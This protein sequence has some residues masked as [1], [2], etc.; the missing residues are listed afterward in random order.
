ML[1]PS[2]LRASAFTLKS[3]INQSI[4]LRKLIVKRHL[5]CNNNHRNP[6]QIEK[7]VR[8]VRGARLKASMTLC[9]A[10]FAFES[11]ED[12]FVTEEKKIDLME[13]LKK[14]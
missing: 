7:R 4:A 13:C 12:I 10:F 5:P 3:G 14:S 1:S 11:R 8:R 6:K 2:S 9:A